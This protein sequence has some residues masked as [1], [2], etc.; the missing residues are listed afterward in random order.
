ML[1]NLLSN[2]I[3]FTPENGRVTV[4]V[5]RV[6]GEVEVAVTDTGPGIPPN[7]LESV[8]ER[9]EREAKYSKKPG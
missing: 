6:A 3:K 7:Q 5:R 4:S 2:A 1:M 8:F 9:I